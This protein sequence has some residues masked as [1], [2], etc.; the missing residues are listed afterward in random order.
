MISEVAK[1]RKRLKKPIIRRSRIE[2]LVD[3]GTKMILSDTLNQ[4]PYTEEMM[5]IT[6]SSR[7]K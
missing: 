7:G 6:Y 4:N 5:S 1:Y 3:L 2:K